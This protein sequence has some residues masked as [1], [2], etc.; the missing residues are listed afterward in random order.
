MGADRE[1]RIDLGVG[2]RRMNKKYYRCGE[3]VNKE[4]GCWTYGANNLNVWPVRET[5]VKISDNC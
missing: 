2:K 3:Y 5:Y 4:N 1:G